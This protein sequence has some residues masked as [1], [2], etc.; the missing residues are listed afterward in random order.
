MMQGLGTI[1]ARFEVATFRLIL[2]KFNV[3]ART[4]IVM[5][6]FFDKIMGSGKGKIYRA[7]Q[8]WSSM[9]ERDDTALKTAANVFERKL[10]NFAHKKIKRESFNQLKDAL[11]EGDALKKRA[12]IQL[13]NA[14]MSGP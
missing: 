1:M 2:W 3:N 14:T 4:R 9:P 13:M 11:Q 8:R 10:C 12:A 6:T 7:F 5:H